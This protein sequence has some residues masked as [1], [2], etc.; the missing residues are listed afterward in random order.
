MLKRVRLSPDARDVSLRG[1]LRELE[2]YHLLHGCVIPSETEGVSRGVQFADCLS[3]VKDIFAAQEKTLRDAG[4]IGGHQSVSSDNLLSPRVFFC[5]GGDY[6]ADV[7]GFREQMVDAG[8]GDVAGRT[9]FIPAPP[10][11]GDVGVFFEARYPKD[12]KLMDIRHRVSERF[13]IQ[14]AIIYHEDV[15]DYQVMQLVPG[16]YTEGLTERSTILERAVRVEE[17]YGQFERDVLMPNGL[18]FHDIVCSR[19]YV[20][21][22]IREEVSASGKT[23]QAYQVVLNDPRAHH[24]GLLEDFPQERPPTATG[25][26]ANDWDGV[27]FVV[28]LGTGERNAFGN[29]MQTDAHAYDQPILVGASLPT[30]EKGGVSPPPDASEAAP[31]ESLKR[32]PYFSRLVVYDN[33]RIYVAGTASIRGAGTIYKLEDFHGPEWVDVGNAAKMVGGK[34]GLEAMFGAGNVM[35]DDHHRLRLRADSAVEAQSFVTI[36]NIAA[37][38]HKDN[39]EQNGVAGEATFNDLTHLIVYIKRPED[40]DNVMRIHRRFFPDNPMIGVV[41]DVCRGD[42]E[43]ETEA[44][45]VLRKNG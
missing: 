14:Y 5:G 40:A 33:E 16:V 42:L 32:P 8:L 43:M 27:V 20:G 31:G 29:P 21:E 39:L 3:Q 23:L 19:N 17:A 26:G 24:Y 7:A 10:V 41:C 44:E 9:V 4:R 37:L 28:T 38:I 30:G 36:D 11:E 12:G 22:I 45:G 13:G 6:A 34:D 1:D 35:E 25:I 18:S 2:N 15:T